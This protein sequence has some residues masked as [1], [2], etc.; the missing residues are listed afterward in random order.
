MIDHPGSVPNDANSEETID[1]KVQQFISETIKEIQ[2]GHHEDIN[3]LNDIVDSLKEH[4]FTITVGV[5]S[6]EV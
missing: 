6:A 5:D 3:S 4:D 1:L 2:L